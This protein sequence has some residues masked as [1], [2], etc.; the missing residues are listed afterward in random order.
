MGGRTA[1][2]LGVSSTSASPASRRSGATTEGRTLWAHMQEE[3][4]RLPGLPAFDPVIGKA[5]AKDPD[6]RYGTCIELIQAVR[7]PT[8]GAL[9][10]PPTRASAPEPAA[11]VPSRTT[12]VAGAPIHD[13]GHRPPCRGCGPGGGADPD[14]RRRELSHGA[15]YSGQFR[16]EDRCW[17]QSHLGG[18]SGWERAHADR[19]RCDRCMGHEL[20]RP[21][22]LQTRSCQR[23][24]TEDDLDRGRRDGRRGGRGRRLGC[25]RVRRHLVTGRS[26]AERDHREH[27]AR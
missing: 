10:R 5:L 22:A 24:G 17:S 2:R 6:E 9:H 3:P 20:R 23:R 21:D 25:A 7:E 27:S 26:R 18:D 15:S 13:P 16:G 8:Q 4:P 11:A 12:R 14:C 1:T 19:R